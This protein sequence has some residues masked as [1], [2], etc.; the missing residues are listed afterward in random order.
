MR[1]E[2]KFCFAM[3]KIL[4]TLLFIA[5]EMKYNFVSPVVGVN[6]PIR[7]ENKPEQNIKL[8][9]RSNWQKFRI[10]KHLTNEF[11]Y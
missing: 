8:S 4:F 6:Q 11:D 2:M 3:K 1:P 7:N 5:G 9:L 10:F